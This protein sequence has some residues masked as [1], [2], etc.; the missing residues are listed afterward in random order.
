MSC[1]IFLNFWLVAK[2][3]LIEHTECST[4]SI[5]IIKNIF[6]F[7]YSESAKG[8]VKKEESK[9]EA[10]E[11]DEHKPADTKSPTKEAAAAST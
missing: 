3:L 6:L 7:L 9:E 2:W 4:S 8:D 5:I 11:V 1:L 10:M